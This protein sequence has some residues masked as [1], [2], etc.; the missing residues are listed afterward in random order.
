M[1]AFVDTNVLLY[2][3]SEDPA[4]VAKRDI[5]RALLAGGQP[6]LLSVQVL[7][8]FVW[9]AAHPRRGTPLSQ[10]AIRQLVEGW[11]ESDVQALDIALF[12]LAWTVA[13]RTNYQW[14]DCLIVAAAIQAGC[15]VLYSEDMHH[16]H[17]VN[18][19]R[20]ENPFRD[21]A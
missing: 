5:A 14:W 3:V 4:E 18:G 8:E 2:S 1:R 9:R 21:L 19:V 11:S 13:D 6:C 7:N 17:V 15:D 12:Q 10:T 20:I 16:G